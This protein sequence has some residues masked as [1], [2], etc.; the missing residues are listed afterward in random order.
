MLIL[1]AS[2]HIKWKPWLC[3]SKFRRFSRVSWRGALIGPTS[4]DHHYAKKLD[5]IESAALLTERG[6][7]WSAAA[8]DAAKLELTPEEY[9]SRVE[10]AVRSFFRRKVLC[11]RD[12]SMAAIQNMWRN[13]GQ[14]GLVLGGKSIGAPNLSDPAD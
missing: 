7:M 6:F 1:N 4:D 2:A 10:R 9:L 13:E 3:A 5:T 8:A 11:D 14:L 12:A